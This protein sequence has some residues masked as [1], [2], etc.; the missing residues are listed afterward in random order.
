MLGI[1]TLAAVVAVGL[2]QSPEARGPDPPRP[3]RPSAGQ[4]RTTLAGAPPAL[5][6]L[7]RQA[8]RILQGERSALRARLRR[9]RGHPVL[10]NVWAAWCGPC[11]VELPVLQRASLR[12]G[13][14]VAFLGVDLR[15]NREAA[16]RLLREIPLTYPSY[17]DPDAKIATGYRLVGTPST[18]FY[19]ARGR[20]TYIHQGPYYGRAE[21]DAQIKRYALGERA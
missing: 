4:V 13:R 9:L 16:H 10:V 15:D 11:R 19:D 8:N 14:R 7:H 17:A 18:V 1:A 2:R 6:A 20:Q 5:A 21:L 12:W 3:A